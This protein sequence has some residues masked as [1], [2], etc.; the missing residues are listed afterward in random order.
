MHNSYFI[1]LS[2]ASV[3]FDSENAPVALILRA[4]GGNSGQY[5]Y[6]VES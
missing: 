3:F 2:I 5:S 4:V 6:T 1:M